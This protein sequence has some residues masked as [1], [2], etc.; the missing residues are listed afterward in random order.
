M[1]SSG[2]DM[3]QIQQEMRQIPIIWICFKIAYFKMKTTFIEIVHLISAGHAQ[4]H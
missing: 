4:E 2:I 3:W 1:G